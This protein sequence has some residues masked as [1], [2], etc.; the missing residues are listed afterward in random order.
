MKPKPTNLPSN[1][2]AMRKAMPS[3]TLQHIMTVT[4]LKY[5]LIYNTLHGRVKVWDKRHDEVIALLRERLNQTSKQ[6]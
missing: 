2:E 6:W 1:I 5:Q 3:G 4:G